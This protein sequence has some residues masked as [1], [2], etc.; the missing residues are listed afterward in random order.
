MGEEDST[1]LVNPYNDFHHTTVQSGKEVKMV[2]RTFQVFNG[3]TLMFE[4]SRNKMEDIFTVVLQKQKSIEATTYCDGQWKYQVTI[5]NGSRLRNPLQCGIYSPYNLF[6]RGIDVRADNE[7]RDGKMLERK[8]NSAGLEVT[9][10]SNDVVREVNATLQAQNEGAPEVTTARY[11]T[12]TYILMGVG[13]L[14][15]ATMVIGALVAA[16]RERLTKR[17]SQVLLEEANIPARKGRLE[18]EY[19]T[20]DITVE[21]CEGKDVKK[22]IRLVEL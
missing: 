11:S 21:H 7:E 17:V 16:I 15:G 9:V 1:F 20:N 6:F 14:V 10:E 12:T 19:K 2:T 18:I 5:S 13:G 22:M 4:P 8:I 3:V